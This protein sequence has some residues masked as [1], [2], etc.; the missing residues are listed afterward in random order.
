[1]AV[2]FQYMIFVYIAGILVSNAQVY[3]DSSMEYL[4]WPQA[5]IAKQ[6]FDS[7]ETFLKSRVTDLKQLYASR[8]AFA[9]MPAFWLAVLDQESYQKVATHPK[10]SLTIEPAIDPGTMFIDGG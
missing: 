2:H 8:S 10:V 5:N 3:G 6:D 4:I 7:V 9:P 1:M